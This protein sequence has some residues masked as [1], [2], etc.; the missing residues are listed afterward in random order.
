MQAIL[1]ADI[2][3]DRLDMEQDYHNM[4]DKAKKILKRM[5]AWNFMTQLEL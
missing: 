2:S 5:H 3:K 4:Y 1:K